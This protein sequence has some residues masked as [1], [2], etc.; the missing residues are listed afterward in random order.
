MSSRTSRRRNRPTRQGMPAAPTVLMLGEIRTYVNNTHGRTRTSRSLD[1]DAWLIMSIL[2][3]YRNRGYQG[4]LFEPFLKMVFFQVKALSLVDNLG[5]EDMFQPDDTPVTLL[6]LA[7]TLARAED[8]DNFAHYGIPA[9]P[10]MGAGA[11]LNNLAAMLGVD[12][13]EDNEDDEG[14][15]DGNTAPAAHALLSKEGGSLIVSTSC[16]TKCVSWI[17][18]A[19]QLV[20]HCGVC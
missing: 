19:W 8:D 15:E 10:Y 3:Y 1:R 14:E 7:R 4:G 12:N 17:R 20:H 11:G 13:D 2:Y 5:L 9:D 6:V 16:W 18:M